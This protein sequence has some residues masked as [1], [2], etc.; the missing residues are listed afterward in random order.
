MSFPKPAY[1][2]SPRQGSILP[3]ASALLVCQCEPPPP[4]LPFLMIRQPTDAPY[5]DPQQ[6]GQLTFWE[7]P[8]CL[9]GTQ[10]TTLRPNIAYRE[11]EN[12]LK[13]GWVG[14]PP[15]IFQV[16]AYLHIP[17]RPKRGRTH[18]VTWHSSK[19]GVSV[20]LAFD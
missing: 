8:I 10:R 18:T 7:K 2:L 13:I 1:I 20:V 17:S 4:V 14:Y 12:F 9:P 19:P 16:C 15:Y 3:P 5:C 6:A 11:V